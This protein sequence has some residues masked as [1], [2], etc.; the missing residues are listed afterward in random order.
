MPKLRPSSGTSACR[1]R[2]RMMPRTLPILRALI[3]AKTKKRLK[4]PTP[5]LQSRVLP[6]LEAM[7]LFLLLDPALLK[8]TFLLLQ[9]HQPAALLW[10]L[11]LELCIT[12]TLSF[13]RSPVCQVQL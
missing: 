2:R 3:L 9:L 7:A 4:M 12:K 13:I 8:S 1:R 10:L 11:P 6:Q 5:K